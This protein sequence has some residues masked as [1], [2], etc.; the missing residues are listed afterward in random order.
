[1]HHKIAS[2]KLYSP[3]NRLPFPL[4]SD[5]CPP[6]GLAKP[7]PTSTKNPSYGPMDTTNSHMGTQLVKLNESTN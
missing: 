3:I 2:I 6:K 1:M 5:G 4:Q 7:K